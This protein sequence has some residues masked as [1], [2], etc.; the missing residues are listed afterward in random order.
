LQIGENAFKVGALLCEDGW[1][2]DYGINPAASMVRNSSVDLFVNL[3]SSPFTL[4]KN[5]KRHRVFSRQ[6]LETGVPLI[7]VNNVGI[8]NNG[9]TIYTFDGCSTAYGVQGEPVAALSAFCRAA[10][11]YIFGTTS[12]RTCEIFRFGPKRQRH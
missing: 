6:A 3:S 7:Y 9:K 8:Q 4:G 5:D 10:G 2:D 11:I 12:D 1:C